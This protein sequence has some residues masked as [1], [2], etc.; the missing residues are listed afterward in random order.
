MI[1]GISQLNSAQPNTVQSNTEQQNSALLALKSVLEVSS[2]LGNNWFDKSLTERTLNYLGLGQCYSEYKIDGQRLLDVLNILRPILPKCN[3]AGKVQASFADDSKLIISIKKSELIE[4][5]ITT[6]E[7][8]DISVSLERS[9]QD[10]L[11]KSLPVAL[12]MPYIQKH[13]SLP[14]IEINGPDDMRFLCNFAAKLSTA[15][16]PHS[17]KTNPLS[18][19]SPLNSIYADTFRGPGNSDVSINGVKLSREA[20]QLLCH[21][22]GLK[23]T[24]SSPPSSIINRGISYDKAVELVV[25]SNAGEEQKERLTAVL[26][27]P[28]FVAAI[29][30]SF[31]Q[32]FTVPA[33][34]L[35]HER[36]SLARQHFAEKLLHLPNA[37][38][39]INISSSSDGGLYV[40]NNV[41]A[42]IM[43]SEDRGNVVGVLT[44]RTS[45]EIPLGTKCEIP[46]LVRVIKPTYSASEAYSR[47]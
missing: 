44:M 42:C 43:A 41:G 47:R 21:F 31:Y 13:H 37:H 7:G 26:C 30:S 4:I 5:T 29:C 18:G 19:M 38:F 27:Q 24:G 36:I 35:M 10:C 15:I 32:S 6:P 39:S 33:F 12:H 34:L 1:N 14:E 22:I 16:V 28:E 11:L 20:Q 23:D 46:E 45:Y 8:R 3:E 40:F 2:Y 17:E 25:K 9:K